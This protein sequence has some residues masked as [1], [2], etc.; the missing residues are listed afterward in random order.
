MSLDER[1]FDFAERSGEALKNIYDLDT[2]VPV[3]TG[4]STLDDLPN[5]TYFY[6]GTPTNLI[7]VVQ[8]PVGYIIV[9]GNPEATDVYTQS[10]PTQMYQGLDFTIAARSKNPTTGVYNAWTLIQSASGATISTTITGVSGPYSSQLSKKAFLS[11]PVYSFR[12]NVF[13]TT[14]IT[15]PITF[16]LPNPSGIGPFLKV[17][18]YLFMGEQRWPL[19]VNY[20]SSTRVATLT[21]ET[22]ENGAVVFKPTT[23]TFPV[24]GF[25]TSATYL[26]EIS[27]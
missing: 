23:T 5:G 10:V 2:G 4:L 16:Q 19:S 11:Q 18:G 6:A 25:T 13:T 26:L 12:L 22:F 17:S 9:R 7:P 14:V 15:G 21:A 8:L 24:S 3:A 1:L 27:P 20:N